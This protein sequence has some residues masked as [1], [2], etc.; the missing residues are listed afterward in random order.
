VS[1][2]TEETDESSRRR[3]LVLL[4][5]AFLAFVGAGTGATNLLGGRDDGDDGLDLSIDYSVT[6]DE[7][8]T[9]PTPTPAANPSSSG[10][11]ESPAA[12]VTDPSERS[13]TTDD[14]AGSETTTDEPW[15]FD[16][17]DDDHRVVA[18]PDPTT[19]TTVTPG[20]DLVTSSIP[21][22]SVSDVEPGDGGVVDLSLALS[23]SPARL[24]VRG[25]ATD[26]DEGGVVEAERS[27]GDTGGSGE[28]QRHV[29]VRL[30]YDADGDGAVGGGDNLVYEGTL[31]DLN[32]LGA[33]G[34]DG[35][36]PL[37]ET[38]VPPGTHTARFR[39]ELPA[40]APNLVQTDSAS[41]S[42]GVAADAGA[43]E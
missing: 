27:A 13:D 36:V 28:L 22:V 19:T 34:A 40:D 9:A 6:P 29:Q 24:W 3:L 37:T 39:W 32:D 11:S 14:G 35:W 25:A 30:W 5:A 42:L 38:C 33:G 43:C 17:P 10:G 15:Q 41:F 18:E 26:F 7:P 1:D 31:A 20:S 12:D 23:G 21:P 2:P 8:N 4:F 16:D